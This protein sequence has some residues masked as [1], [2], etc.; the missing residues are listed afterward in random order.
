MKTL[1]RKII[2]AILSPAPPLY[3]L[4]SLDSA[5]RYR[6]A[7]AGAPLPLD[8]PSASVAL[9]LSPWRLCLCDPEPPPSRLSTSTYLASEVEEQQGAALGRSWRS[10][11]GWL[12]GWRWMG[13]VLGSGRPMPAAFPQPCPRS[14]SSAVAPLPAAGCGGTLPR[15]WPPPLSSISRVR[16]SSLGLVGIHE[17]L[18][19]HRC[20]IRGYAAPCAAAMRASVRADVMHAPLVNLTAIILNH[21]NFNF[22]INKEN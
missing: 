22:T 9:C 7:A 12:V 6:V 8:L 16:S 18:V 4:S 21:G 11:E 15:P 19:D 2:C 5:S 20:L 17:R 10:S 3:S 14:S 1:D 13:L